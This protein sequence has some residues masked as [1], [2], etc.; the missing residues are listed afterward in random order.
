M[1]LYKLVNYYMTIFDSCASPMAPRLAPRWFTAF[2]V[3]IT[4]LLNMSIWSG[5]Y[6]IWLF[7][8]AARH[9]WPFIQLLTGLPGSRL[10]LPA[11]VVVRTASAALRLLYGQLEGSTKHRRRYNKRVCFSFYAKLRLIK[12]FDMWVITNLCLGHICDCLQSFVTTKKGWSEGSCKLVLS[13][14]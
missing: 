8:T 14:R 7:F 13:D 9:Q 10:A 6:I 12:L 4:S 11:S 1:C 2:H 3:I 5:L